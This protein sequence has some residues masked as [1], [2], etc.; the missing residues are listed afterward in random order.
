MKKALKMLCVFINTCLVVGFIVDIIDHAKNRINNHRQNFYERWIK[1]PL[2]FLCA[3]MALIVLSPVMAVTS[4]L[5]KKRLGSPVIFTQERPGLNE[6]IFKLYKFRSMTDERDENGELLPN[7]ERITPF[8]EKIRATSMDELPELVNI[9]KGDMSIV[10]PRPL[11]VRYLPYY[12][13]TEKERHSVRP[14]L[15]GLAQVTNEGNLSWDDKLQVDVDYAE[16]ITFLGDLKVIF[17]TIKTVFVREDTHN[18]GFEPLDVERS[19]KILQG[20]SDE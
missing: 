7:E 9:I 5:I 19:Q 8:G 2:D 18:D 4:F 14:G 1:R 3:S 15:T 20:V 16:N 6:K 13:D 10:G 17:K 12:T 11:L